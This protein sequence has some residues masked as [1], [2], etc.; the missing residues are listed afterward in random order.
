MQTTRQ[1]DLDT[2]RVPREPVPG[3]ARPTSHGPRR[4]WPWLLGAVV[5]VGGSIAA[6]IG[7]LPQA[8]GNHSV[9]AQAPTT[10][11]ETAV[12]LGHVDVDGGVIYLLPVQPGRVKEVCKKEN[13]TVKK[14]EVL[15][16]LDNKL[17]ALRVQEAEADLKAAEATLEQALKLPEQHKAQMQQQDASVGAA[18][19]DLQRARAFFDKVKDL[20]KIGQAR[21]EDLRAASEQVIKA[22]QAELAEKAKLTELKLRLPQ[23]GIERARSDVEA[24][25]ARLEQAQFARDECEVKAPCDGV[26][27]RLQVAVGELV[28]PQRP[29]PCVVFCPSTP[30]I[31]RAEVEQEFA[32]RVFVGQNATV[33]D[34]T[35]VSGTWK[36]KVRSL[37]DWYSHRRSM[38]LEPRQFND[39]RTMEAIIEL[40]PDQPP[41]RIG[42]RVRV[43]LSK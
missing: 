43:S 12:C 35:R 17:E 37:S 13:D 1:V 38:L 21:D 14:N 26:V 41:L 2:Q 34:D 33:Q 16:R 4:I 19:S 9:A 23:I 28:G 42:Q 10:G 31:I 25:K 18:A 32:G 27:L 36:G 20:N 7:L 39:V 5:L 40:D 6:T 15:F 22:E 11:E 8:N 29:Q 3:S 30:R 24:K